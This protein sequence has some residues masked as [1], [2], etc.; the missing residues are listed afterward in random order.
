[1]RR[2]RATGAKVKIVGDFRALRREE[3]DGGLDGGGWISLGDGMSPAGVRSAASAAPCGRK[4]MSRRLAVFFALVLAP[5][6][7]LA[8]SIGGSTPPPGAQPQ[9]GQ[10]PQQGTSGT[11]QRPQ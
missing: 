7:A 11:G 9:S 2:L 3:D 5:S 6:L 10:P 1:M 4:A 8:A